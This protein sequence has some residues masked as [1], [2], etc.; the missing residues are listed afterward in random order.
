MLI[1]IQ[2]LTVFQNHRDFDELM[3]RSRSDGAR[4]L[5]WGVLGPL[6]RN[7]LRFCHCGISS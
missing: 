1:Q 2:G 6:Q 4:S 5:H 3:W 7:F